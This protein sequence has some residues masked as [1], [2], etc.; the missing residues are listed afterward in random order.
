MSKKIEFS[1]DAEEIEISCSVT[2]FCPGTGPN[3]DGPGDPPE[4]GDIED[5]YVGVIIKGTTIDITDKLN[6]KQREYIE[7]RV[8]LHVEDSYYF[9]D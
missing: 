4:G 7:E 1:L 3:M 5:L 9:E 8:R 2:P 6:I